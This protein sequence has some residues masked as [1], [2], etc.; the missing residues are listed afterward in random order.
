MRKL[1]KT[2]SLLLCLLLVLQLIG[3]AGE[4][5][6]EGGPSG[7]CSVVW[8]VSAKDAEGNERT[9]T[10]AEE[11]AGALGPGFHINWGKDGDGAA[12]KTPTVADLRRN[13]VKITPPSGYSVKSVFLVAEGSS[14]ESGSRSLLLVSR[15]FV[16]G[17]CAVTLPAAIFDNNYNAS[18]VGKV[19][20]GSGEVY[21][22][23]IALERLP[24]G[25]GIT[26]TYTAGA[27][28]SSLGDITL[29]ER[30]N[31][32]TLPIASGETAVSGSFAAL[33]S[34]VAEQVVNSLGKEFNGWKLTMSNG[35]SV[36]VQGGDPFTLSDSVT[37]EALWKKYS[38]QR[39]I[40]FTVLNVKG[41]YNGTAY[42][43]TDYT[44]SSGELAEGHVVNA[45]F[46]GQQ[47]LP[48]KSTGTASF[49]IAD[50]DGNDVS[51][52]YKI[53]VINCVIEVTPRS[54][55]VPLTVTIS[56]AEKE[57]DGTADVSAAYALTE[58]SLLGGDKLS[59]SVS[60]SITG[61]G[62]GSLS[63]SFSVFNG[64]ADVSENYEITVVNGTLTVKPR[65]IT[66]TAD[67]AEKD[68][69]NE[70][71]TKDSYAISSGSL[72]E[73][74]TLTATVTGTQTAIGSSANKIDPA[75]VKIMDGENDATA[76]YEVTLVDG[77][78]T[79]K[80]PDAPTE[81]TI[82]MKSA[83]KTYDGKALTSKE[84][85]ISSGA[86]AEGDKLLIGEVTGTQTD[87]GESSVTAP[88]K[89]IRG[90]LDVSSLYKITVVPGK[91]TVKPRPIT[92]TAG[93]ASKIY[94]GRPLT[95]TSWK[96]SSGELVKGHKM[97]AS[98]TGSQTSI[99]SSANVIDKASIKI[100]DGSGND[101]AKNYKV[102]TAAGTLTVTNDPITAITLSVGDSSKVYDGKP[103]RF[104]SSDIKVTSGSL[105]SGYRI[106]ATF[107]PE[108]PT[109]VGR[110][111]ITIKSVTI[112]NASG[113]D[114][115]N[116]FNISR[117]KGTLTISERPLTIETKAANKVF[118][119]TPL[120]ERSTPN[121]T[122]RVENHQVTLRITGSQT[123]VGSSDNT[124]SD[125]KITDKDTGADVTKNYA[126]TYQYGKLTVTEGSDG[127]SGGSG[128][129][130]EYV[131][132]SG[133]AGTL[134]IT[135]SHDYNG[136]E[137][138]QVD[139][140]DLD[141]SSYTSASGSTE[142]W[143]KAAYLNTLSPGSYTLKAKYS[144]GETE[145][146]K[147]TVKAAQSGRTGDSN[148]L[149]LW[150]AILV[151]ALLAALAAAGYLLLGK[152]RRWRKRR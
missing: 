9:F 123:K 34:A 96:L 47:T 117:A 42:A 69:D 125:V 13:G 22:L 114:V 126:I 14:P 5:F 147:F 12:I 124:V 103:Y 141:R 116:K 59:G 52:Q 92:A 49:T 32:V 57:Y 55:K 71:L 89:V 132:I 27:L 51:G 37:L 70:P 39:P 131:W 144:G 72:V 145:Q 4:A 3:T 78:L 151:I 26:L 44:I 79:V 66:L 120:T 23:D 99:G 33:D 86:L 118:D 74:H 80:G 61:V 53:S 106:E 40:T 119:G 137:G 62:T 93:S 115:T 50:A 15:A 64:D 133:S 149:G 19:F 127:G 54:E 88:F 101:V 75:S 150:I 104:L 60:G 1:T 107:N 108:A 30:G 91:L 139:G 85:E 16:N 31:S 8:S 7:D 97:T 142:I 65:P 130:G 38:S 17:S 113:T 56:D 84:Y 100:T 24:S 76:Q 41:E 109:E 67:S 94:D 134:F 105:P 18:A 81:I 28:A 102:T 35:A 20:N 25:G 43:P 135:F 128:S 136:F 112:R 90:E 121:I 10:D 152:D 83:E 98:V 129:E 6:A 58:G 45:V 77:T 95:C 110:Y 138:L 29:V 87:A 146:A 48:G 68:F 21:V 11:L 46:S 36:T 63:G 140:K 2:I 148:H 73:G 143:L 122:G 82:T 111:E